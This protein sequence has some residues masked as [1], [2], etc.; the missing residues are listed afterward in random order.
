LAALSV[1][2]GEVPQ[3]GLAAIADEMPVPGAAVA[4]HLYSDAVSTAQP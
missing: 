1:S 3:F 4:I 2:I